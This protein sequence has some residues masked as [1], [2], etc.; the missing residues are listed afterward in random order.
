MK[1]NSL[2]L[3][4]LGYLEEKGCW[5]GSGFFFNGTGHLLTIGSTRSGKGVSIIA[6]N[7]AF[8]NEGS[9]V[10]LDPKGENAAITARYRE[11][12]LGQK[13]FILDPW[14]QFRKHEWFQARNLYE[15]HQHQFTGFNPLDSLN[16]D[17]LETETFLDECKHIAN[18]IIPRKDGDSAGAYFM[19]KAN[20]YL[21]GW[22]MFLMAGECDTSPMLNAND[23]PLEKT[24]YTFLRWTRLNKRQ[25]EIIWNAMIDNEA[26]D[27]TIKERIADRGNACLA[28][29]LND[30]TEYGYIMTSLQDNL[31][32]FES[33]TLLKSARDAQ[34]QPSMLLDGKTTLYIVIPEEKM[35][36]NTVWMR[37][38]VRACIEI[39]ISRR[40][41]KG[42]TAKG[43]ETLFML[44]EFPALGRMDSIIK[45]LNLAAG[46][47]LK[48]W[49]IVQ[50]LGAV[51]G[52]LRKNFPFLVS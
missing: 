28:A 40:N 52:N 7:L 18:E 51:R 37:L 3:E 22:L 20:E 11:E 35:T 47:G 49:I 19:R 14:E 6:Q 4:E 29:M 13:V 24:L 46:M 34:F 48:F 16:I 1:V 36:S 42:I 50:N 30:S 17:L 43:K 39:M 26:V 45:N 9:L 12:G 27:P 23:I 21:T 33:T 25:Q 10:I 5:I 32:L 8:Y 41:L 31:E 15:K 44:D 2:N 38:V